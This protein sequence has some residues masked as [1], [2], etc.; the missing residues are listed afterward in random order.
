MVCLHHA[1]WRIPKQ[2]TI[3]E[4]VANE[5]VDSSRSYK[6]NISRTGYSNFV[7]L[8]TR[9]FRYA[10]TSDEDE[11]EIVAVSVACLPA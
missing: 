4:V 5:N 9:C 3:V 7:R 1:S 8:L 6:S 10:L 2:D 11:S